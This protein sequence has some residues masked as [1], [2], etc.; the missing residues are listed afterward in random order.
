ME[1]NLNREDRMKIHDLEDF[2]NIGQLELEQALEGVA[3]YFKVGF[4]EVL[5]EPK[6][7]DEYSG[8]FKVDFKYGNCEHSHII[9]IDTEDL[10]AI[11]I[12][13]GESGEIT[14]ITYG[15]VMG[16]FYFDLALDDL[17]DEYLN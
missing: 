7:M 9:Q 10:E 8:T 11:G 16:C 17:A 14:P 5:S 1:I 15:N 6:D 13:H 4:D 2:K 12:S 3:T